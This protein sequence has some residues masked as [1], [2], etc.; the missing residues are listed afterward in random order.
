MRILGSL[1]SVLRR[2]MRGVVTETLSVLAL[3]GFAVV[4]A[5]LSTA[6]F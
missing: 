5:L 2:G 1:S 3:L 6:V 4:V